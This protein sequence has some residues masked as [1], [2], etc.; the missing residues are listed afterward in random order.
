MTRDRIV[1]GL[2]FLAGLTMIAMTFALMPASAR[3]A[4]RAPKDKGTCFT[5]ANLKAGALNA[6]LTVATYA[7]EEAQRAIY[8]YNNLPPAND[9]VT[10]DTAVLLVGPALA[11]LWVGTSKKL[12][13]K[14]G[15]PVNTVPAVSRFLNGQDS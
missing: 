12:C 4:E 9:R 8:L 1:S 14:V 5:Q 7:G 11:E 3:S 2:A 6:G 15:L 10:G 13:K